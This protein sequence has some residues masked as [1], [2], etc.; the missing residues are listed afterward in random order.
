M[1]TLRCR[2]TGYEVTGEFIAKTDDHYILEIGGVTQMFRVS[3]W[4]EK[5]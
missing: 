2:V 5:R 1:T 3:E 4:E